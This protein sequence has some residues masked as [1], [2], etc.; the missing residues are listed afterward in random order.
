MQAIKGNFLECNVF[1]LKPKCDRGGL[2]SRSLGEGKESNILEIC[3][4]L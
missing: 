4:H 1:I 3:P 2:E